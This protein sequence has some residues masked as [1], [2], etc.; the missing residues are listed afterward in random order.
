[1][2]GKT[3]LPLAR[4][5]QTRAYFK[6]GAYIKIILKNPV[7]SYYR[8][9]LIIGETRYQKIEFKGLEYKYMEYFQLL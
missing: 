3:K 6:G 4:A 7:M 2:L 8:V 1:M 5:H 9:G